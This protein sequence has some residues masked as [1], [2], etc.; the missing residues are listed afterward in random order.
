LQERAMA[1]SKAT[2]GPIMVESGRRS[3]TSMANE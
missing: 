2:S 1:I 3:I